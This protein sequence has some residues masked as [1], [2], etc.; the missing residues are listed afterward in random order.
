MRNKENISTPLKRRVRESG[1]SRFLQIVE[2]R[3]LALVIADCLSE[4]RQAGNLFPLKR[5][6]FDGENLALVYFDEDIDIESGN[7]Q[8]QG[9]RRDEN[10]FPVT[11]GAIAEFKRPAAARLIQFSQ[12]CAP[13]FHIS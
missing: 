1:S 5:R 13:I 11:F 10:C 2:L 6:A 8:G 12:R 3:G 9:Y 7:H 4:F